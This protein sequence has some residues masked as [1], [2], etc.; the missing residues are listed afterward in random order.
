MFVVWFCISSLSILKISEQLL[1]GQVSPYEYVLTYQF[2]QD[3]IEMHFQKLE[4]DLVPTWIC[5]TS[6]AIK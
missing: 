5:D 6:T 4:V 1:E 2:S 3:Q